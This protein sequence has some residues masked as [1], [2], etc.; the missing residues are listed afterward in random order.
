MS[1][2]NLLVASGVLWLPLVASQCAP[3]LIENGRFYYVFDNKTVQPNQPMALNALF[4]AECFSNYEYT[5]RL[6]DQ[7]IRS[8]IV[9]QCWENTAQ[10]S[11][12][13]DVGYCKP[14]LGQ[15][16]PPPGI[17]ILFLFK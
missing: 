4:A 12:S 5:A 8:Q 11:P 10:I 16:P 14:L 15:F 13:P 17:I 2:F 7:P 6:D 3:P 9:F 1:L